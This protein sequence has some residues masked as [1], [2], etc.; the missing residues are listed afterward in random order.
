MINLNDNNFNFRGNR[1]YL[2]SASVINF[3]LKKN[4]IFNKIV[5]KKFSINQIEF[6]NNISE[7][8]FGIIDYKNFNRRLYMNETDKKILNRELYD[9]ELLIKNSII[10]DSEIFIDSLNDNYTVIDLFIALTKKLNQNLYPSKKKWIACDLTITNEYF[11]NL[12]KDPSKVFNI[13]V[14]RDKFLKP[15]ISVNILHIDKVE[16]AKTRFILFSN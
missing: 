8:N 14:K 2:H 4:F 3:L 13:E 11:F 12:F 15:F 1:N 5:F 10:N 7:N 6:S 9:E 16:Y